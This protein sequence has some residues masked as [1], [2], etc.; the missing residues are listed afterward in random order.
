MLHFDAAQKWYWLPDQTDTEVIVFKAVDSDERFSL[1]AC[2][3]PTLSRYG[4]KQPKHYETLALLT[5][6]LL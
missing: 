5:G 3:E 6:R 2:L 4:G 1:G